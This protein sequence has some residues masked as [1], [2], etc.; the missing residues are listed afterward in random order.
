M[1]IIKVCALNDR[2]AY[3]HLSE[4]LAEPENQA[5]HHHETKRLRRK[6][7]GKNRGHDYLR[8]RVHE[9]RNVGPLHTPKGL[10]GE[11]AGGFIGHARSS[12]Q[13]QF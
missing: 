12:L 5:C 2:L 13:S 3:A 1:I 7:T 4:V 6:K 9:S 11:A 8:T 10:G